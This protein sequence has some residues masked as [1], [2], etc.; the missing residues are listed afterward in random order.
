MKTRHLVFITI[1][2]AMAI[3]AAVPLRAAVTVTPA[4]PPKGSAEPPKVEAPK[5]EPPKTEAPKAELPLGKP[6][7][8]RVSETQY[9]STGMSGSINLFGSKIGSK[10]IFAIIDLSGGNLGDGDE[11]KIQYIPGRATDPSKANYWVERPEGVL[12]AKEGD[13]FKIKKVGTK[14]A[15]QT[16][17]GKFVTGTI[18]DITLQISDKKES[19]LLVEF[20]DLSAGIP[21]SPKKSTAEAPAAE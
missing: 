7:A 10:Q 18:G 9:V 3:L 21:K 1:T 14:Y 6:V 5:V 17:S 16:P 2:A 20:V 15:F 11:V 4:E 12:R 19:A 8:F 13:I